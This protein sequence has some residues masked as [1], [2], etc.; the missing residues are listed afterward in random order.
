MDSQR[1]DHLA[2]SLAKATGRRQVLRGLGLAALGGFF[3]RGA[4]AQEVATCSQDSDCAIPE[5]DPCS[6]VSCQ[7]GTCAVFIVDCIPGFVCCNNGQCCEDVPACA[8]DA[9]CAGSNADPCATTS[10]IDGACATSLVTCAPG[11]TCCGGG[12]APVCPEGQA[13]DAACQCVSPGGDPDSGDG[14]P[15]DGT[16]TV[17][18]NDG[19]V[20]ATVGN[21]GASASS[22]GRTVSVGTLSE[23]P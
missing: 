1:F 8:T 16:M 12:C 6:G 21:G 18:A 13:F 23:G 20:T 10:C 17:T 3:A 14:T 4:A 19:G 9:D 7:D 15:D 22:G 5:G 11:F 2:R